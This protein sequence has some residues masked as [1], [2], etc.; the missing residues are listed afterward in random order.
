M[1]SSQINPVLLKLGPLGIR[2]Y[3]LMYV[4]GLVIIYFFIQYLAKQRR[5]KISKEEIADFLFWGI[6][7][8]I[9]GARIFYILFYN[10]QYFISNQL[11]VFAVWEGGLSWHGGLAGIL[12]AGFIF[13][14]A[15]KISFWELA[16]I[17]VIPISAC[18]M[19]GRI[20]N[21]LNNELYGRISSLPW[22]VKFQGVD[23][24]RHPSQLYESFKNL[25]I[26]SVLWNVKDKKLPNG[27]MF[28]FFLVMYSA[29]RFIIEFFRQPD[30]QLGFVFGQFSMGQMLNVPVFVFGLGLLVYFHKSYKQKKTNIK[31]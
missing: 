27:M 28:S 2:Y 14:R 6:I 15:K 29:F 17:S 26:F 3:G 5:I 18:L 13:C 12:V 24:F 8:V 16:D 30:E 11:K 7:G 10:L 25:V 1:L 22:A 31:K 20:G 4:L 9:A 19:L 21:F 23:G